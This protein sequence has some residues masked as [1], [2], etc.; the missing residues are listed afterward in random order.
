MASHALNPLEASGAVEPSGEASASQGEGNRSANQPGQSETV[1][2]H[3]QCLEYSQKV[4]QRSRE[5]P[6]L[7]RRFCTILREY[8][9]GRANLEGT[10]RRMAEI[11]VNVNSIDL[12]E[13]FEALLLPRFRATVNQSERELLALMAGEDVDVQ[14]G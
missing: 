3:T 4:Q 11:F 5:H 6:G 8:N 10:R 14:T 2:S 9:D 12:Y 13:E 1:P 7:F